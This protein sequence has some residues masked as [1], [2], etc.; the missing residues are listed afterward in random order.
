ML[1]GRL[2]KRLDSVE[3]EIL[4]DKICRSLVDA[5]R[6]S[7]D[8]T[9]KVNT[10]YIE[11]DRESFVDTYD[12]IRDFSDSLETCLYMA[13]NGCDASMVSNELRIFLMELLEKEEQE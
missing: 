3:V 1:D 6:V 10:N 8:A 4:L 11:S 5:I 9:C 12:I 13:S 7:C 2:N